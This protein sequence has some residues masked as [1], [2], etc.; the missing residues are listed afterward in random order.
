MDI[1]HFIGE[2]H[3]ALALEEYIH[4]IDLG[5]AVPITGLLSRLVRCGADANDIAFK[6]MVDNPSACAGGG[7]DEPAE[8]FPPGI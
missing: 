1:N 4:L 3:L 7:G 6:L 5:V 8:V 2:A